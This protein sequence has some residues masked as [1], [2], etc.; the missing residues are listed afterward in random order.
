MEIHAR[1]IGDRRSL[2]QGHSNRLHRPPE[3]QPHQ[4]AA[5]TNFHARQ[6]L[7]VPYAPE[8]NPVELV[9]NYLKTNPLA[10]LAPHDV[11]ELTRVANRSAKVVQAD[12]NMYVLSLKV[13]R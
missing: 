11:E 3:L 1:A 9:W 10:N 6:I 8:W 4:V 2:R 13:P 5:G 12:E 7:P